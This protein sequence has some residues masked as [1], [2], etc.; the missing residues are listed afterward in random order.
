MQDSKC[1]THHKYFNKVKETNEIII[2]NSSSFVNY[3]IEVPGRLNK[4]Y[5][6]AE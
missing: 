5:C 6:Y 3:N 2:A 1:K 4:N